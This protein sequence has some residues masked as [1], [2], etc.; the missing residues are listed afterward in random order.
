MNKK[1][2]LVV[3]LIVVIASAITYVILNK[4]AITAEKEVMTSTQQEPTVADAHMEDVAP[5]LSKNG[6]ITYTP[7][8]I[9]QT[10][11]TTLLFFYAPWCPQC[12]ALDADIVAKG[13]P[14]GITI[15]KVDYDSH[16][17]LR[18]KYGVTI[19]TTIVTVDH[20]GNLLKKFVAYDE[21]TLAAV[22]RG[23]F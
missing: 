5:A 4:P 13:V 16:Q 10:K 8:S 11:G 14:E 6:Y 20:N 12:R 17:D 7:D 21:P 19:Q 23:V 2:L 1:L 22:L 15:I 9:A 3:A 18:Q